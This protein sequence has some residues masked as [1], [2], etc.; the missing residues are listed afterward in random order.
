MS[1]TTAFLAFAGTLAFADYIGP[2]HDWQ[3]LAALTG[4][5]LFCRALGAQEWRWLLW[6]ALALSV[7]VA[8]LAVVQVALWMPRARGPF[9]S[10]NF[11]GAASVLVLFLALADRQMT[12]KWRA[13]AIATSLLTIA[14]S[15]SRG[16]ILALGAGVAVSAIF[17]PGAK[18]RHAAV[19]G[20]ICA[21]AAALL[22]RPETTNP[23]TAIWRIALEA[24]LQRP[25]TG[26][27]QGGLSIGGLSQFYSIPLDVLAAAGILGLA[28]GAWLL[29]VAAKV[30]FKESPPHLAFLAAWFVQ[31]LFLF[32]IPATNVLL[33][34][35]LAWLASG[36][37]GRRRQ[38]EAHRAGLVDRDEVDLR[39][40]RL[41][42]VG[43]EQLEFA[44]LG[45]REAHPFEEEVVDLADEA[46]RINGA[47]DRRRRGEDRAAGEEA[48][49]EANRAE[50]VQKLV[51][52]VPSKVERL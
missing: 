18:F 26:W 46:G 7:A 35:V 25:L 27:G 14:L 20:L 2:G 50:A 23:R 39:S 28:A 32:P 3:G 24:A 30:A 41:V 38:D 22:I 16:A 8:A 5:F 29:F 52:S 6:A 17:S 34:T 43:A 13:A 40:R 4:W 47:G 33:V 9:A 11:A 12:A 48:E 42:G 19:L 44:V 36:V 49:A 21:G 1:I 51:H 10:P 15:Q 31:G 37:G 45:R